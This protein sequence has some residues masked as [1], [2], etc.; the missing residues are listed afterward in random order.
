MLLKSI[1][2]AKQYL[3]KILNGPLTPKHLEGLAEDFRKHH[4]RKFVEQIGTYHS[5]INETNCFNDLVEGVTQDLFEVHPITLE[6]HDW[7]SR[8]L[9]G[10]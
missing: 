8:T 6:E 9:L 4:N 3:N 10:T 5:L 2:V 7:P 1:N